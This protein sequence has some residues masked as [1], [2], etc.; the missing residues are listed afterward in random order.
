MPSN[1]HRLTGIDVAYG[2]AIIGCV[3]YGFWF[4][5]GEQ[6]L[7]TLTHTKFSLVLDSLP[8]LFF[9][10]N[11]FTVTLT[12]R[13][14]KVSNRKLLTYLGKRGSVLFVVGLAFCTVWPMN[15]FVASGLMYVAAPFVAQWN[16]LVLRLIT[17]LSVLFGITLLYVDVPTYAVYSLPT[18]GGG[19]VYNILG[20]LLFNGYY[21]ILPWFT[22]F[23]AGLLFGRTE[24]RPRGI[25]PPSSFVGI[26]MMI[27]SYFVNNFAKKID[28]DVLLLQRSDI[29]F[30]NI[31][32]LYPAFIVFSIG[33]SIV[34]I[35]SLMFIFRKVEN[36]KTLRI[37]QT[38]S[39]MKY[40]VFFFHTIIGLLTLS[41][42]NLQFFSRRI[43]LFVYVILA[44]SLTIYLTFLWRKRVSET[45]PMEWLIK[46]ISGSAKK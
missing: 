45:G 40:S 46:R 20:F 11:G 27:G 36:K 35:N 16:S 19:E 4:T 25:L 17:L 23:F 26:A 38:L 14:R 33:F 8:A 15:I 28:K 29:F 39:S 3:I 32:Q 22:F 41:A 10:L 5:I 9:F 6:V 2:A 30:L 7:S 31:K 43:V 13:D 42:S 34:F 1:S 24:V 37:I 18:L 44:T 12:M 21:S